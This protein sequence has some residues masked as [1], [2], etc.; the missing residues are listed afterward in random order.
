MKA[1]NKE[2]RVKWENYNNN[3]KQWA[4]P[5]QNETNSRPNGNNGE[6]TRIQTISHEY[7][8]FDFIISQIYRSYKLNISFRRN[9]PKAGE[10]TKK[11]NVR[12]SLNKWNITEMEI[13]AIKTNSAENEK[14]SGL[15]QN[16]KKRNDFILGF[17]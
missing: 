8:S 3:N 13:T 6:K 9:Q 12:N 7:V 4:D 1:S 14:K 2:K 10:K 17:R 11:K 5:L 15:Q 16:R